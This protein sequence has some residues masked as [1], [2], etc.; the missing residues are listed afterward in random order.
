[1]TKNTETRIDNRMSNFGLRNLS[2]I[3]QNL[4]WSIV[5][6]IKD[7]GSEEIYIKKSEIDAISKY[8]IYNRSRNSFVKDMRTMGQKV[9]SINTEIY[10]EEKKSWIIFSV[11]PVY[12]VS[13]DGVTI[14]V[15]EYFLPWFNDIQKNFTRIDLSVLIGL[16]SGYSKE[17]YRFLMR[18]K[19]V[20]RGHKY[21]GF[22]NVSLDEFKRLMCVPDSYALS[23]LDRKILTPV[24]E[25]LT[26]VND[27]G[28]A[29]LEYLDI[30]LIMKPNRKK[31]IE[32]IEFTFKQG[33]PSRKVVEEV[34]N[35]T[36]E[37][38]ELGVPNEQAPYTNNFMNGYIPGE[39]SPTKGFMAWLEKIDFFKNKEYFSVR[40]NA[41][42]AIEGLYNDYVEK[43]EEPIWTDMRFFATINKLVETDKSMTSWNLEDAF[44]QMRKHPNNDDF[45]ATIYET[46]PE[47]KQE[48]LHKFNTTGK[49]D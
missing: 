31:Q 11:F 28:W 7:K 41:K 34:L 1:M 3:E 23:D 6:M 26:R 12:E 24:K 44:V 30:N 19:N 13:K 18:W 15:S 38:L 20:R 5:K 43:S 16:R 9:V 10:D 27:D 45:S 37:L 4:W 29:P 39:N 2:V 49:L 14:K 17:L 33:T 8:S 21:P 35:Y 46:L 48:Q 47:D 22:W 40:L 42:K 36:E 25:E 32:R